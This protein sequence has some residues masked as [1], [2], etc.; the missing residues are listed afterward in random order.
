MRKRGR[1]RTERG[2]DRT[3]R[4]CSKNAKR[5]PRPLTNVIPPH[6]HAAFEQLC[7]GQAFWCSQQLALTEGCI[8]P[9]EGGKK[10]GT[11]GIMKR[12]P[13]AEVA[14]DPNMPALCAYTRALFWNSVKPTLLDFADIMHQI[15]YHCG[16][17]PACTRGSALLTRTDRISFSARASWG[18]VP[19]KCK[20]GFVGPP[21]PCNPARVDQR[22]DLIGEGKE[23]ATQGILVTVASCSPTMRFALMAS[24][25]GAALCGSAGFMCATGPSGSGG[26]SA[27]IGTPMS[28]TSGGSRQA[29][30]PRYLS[31]SFFSKGV[32]L[33][34][35]S[36]GESVTVARDLERIKRTCVTC[37]QLLAWL[38]GLS[39]STSRGRFCPGLVCVWDKT[40]LH[41][42]SSCNAEAQRCAA[43]SLVKRSTRQ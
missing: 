12:R 11:E 4:R 35:V 23:I 39:H 36:C 43:L 17:L 41:S 7:I 32:R 42:M 19:E 14:I 8:V 3:P 9:Q 34:G 37:R 10:P 24:C 20:R 1:E 18:S 25:L 15:L 22:L 5:Y 21:F 28:G 38:L 30:P 27:V 26:R 13:S 6:Y 2:R 29:A 33:P 40:V 31:T 16:H